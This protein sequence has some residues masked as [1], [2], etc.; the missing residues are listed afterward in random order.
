[1]K[2][3][4]GWAN[5]SVGILA[6]VRRKSLLNTSQRN[7]TMDYRFQA[8]LMIGLALAA[9]AC[10][11]GDDSFQGS[12][13][14]TEFSVAPTEIFEG[15]DFSVA[16]EAENTGAKTA[17]ISVEE[18]GAN[19]MIDACEQVFDIEPQGFNIVSSAEPDPYSLENGQ[20]LRLEWEMSHEGSVPRYGR[21]CDLSF[22]MPFNYSVTA[23]TQIQIV[24][25]EGSE[26][27][28]DLQHK[29]STGPLSIDVTT[30]PS[31]NQ[32]YVTNE[33]EKVEVL[34]KMVNNQPEEDRNK[35][36]VNINTDSVKIEANDP[37]DFEAEMGPDGE[38][39][40]EG[41]GS[42]SSP[43]R[44]IPVFQGESQTYR[45]EIT[46]PDSVEISEV[47]EIS[48]GFSYKYVK[49]VGTKTIKVKTRG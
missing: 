17:N 1:L 10:V 47:S 35:G 26:I 29:S 43:G 23:F 39:E 41:D 18:N 32:R 11:G 24:E 33:D 14:I 48:I 19:V 6:G 36:L 25:N 16:L 12:I 22:Q 27:K 21:E 40:S 3:Q 5:R 13:Q 9:S 2:T 31:G 30:I 15:Q 8:I 34:F 46:L 49:D 45:C 4:T 42:C 37:L 38:W 7:Y 44:D 28:P 20:G